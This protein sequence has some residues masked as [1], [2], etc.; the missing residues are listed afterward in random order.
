MNLSEV[1]KEPV[2]TASE[3]VSTSIVRVQLNGPGQFLNNFALIILTI[4]ELCHIFTLSL[5][6]RRSWKTVLTLYNLEHM[7]LVSEP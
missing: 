6:M 7:H 2:C 3:L 1:A 4:K 5:L